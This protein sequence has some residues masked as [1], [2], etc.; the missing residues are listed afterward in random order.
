[1]V[2]GWVLNFCIHRATKEYETLPQTNTQGKWIQRLGRVASAA[3]SKGSFSYAIIVILTICVCVCPVGQL[4]NNVCFLHTRIGGSL[5]AT[6]TISINY[7]C[8][9]QTAHSLHTYIAAAY[10]LVHHQVCLILVLCFFAD[11]LYSVCHFSCI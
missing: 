8:Y 3:M 11:A 1:M 2:V 6:V 10:W 4:P 7:H 9:T 5:Y